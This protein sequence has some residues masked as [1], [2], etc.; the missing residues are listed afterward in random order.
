MRR[1]KWV[2]AW[3][4]AGALFSM[5][6][7]TGECQAPPTFLQLLEQRHVN[8]TP[9]ALMEA[10]HDRDKAVRGL[11]AAELAEQKVLAALPAILRAA[12]EETDPQT[13]VNIA[14]AATWMGSAEGVQMLKAACADRSYAAWIRLWAARG[15]FERGDHGCFPAV[16]Q[17]IRGEDAAGRMEALSEASQIQ[18]MTDEERKTVLS[19]AVAALEDADITVRLEACEALR[20]MKDA[21]AVGPLRRAMEMEREEVVRSRM[22]ET[23]AELVKARPGP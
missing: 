15:V 12:E 22:A 6:V 2:S 23:V 13:R 18:P 7:L 9:A 14:S 11:A 16:T 1:V 21:T 17:M 8:T 3:V 20:W 19:L 10:L 4:G 5:A